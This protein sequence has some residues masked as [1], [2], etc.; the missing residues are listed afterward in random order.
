[1]AR[2]VEGDADRVLVEHESHGV[3]RLD[4]LHPQR[5]GAEV[6]HVRAEAARHTHVV[7]PVTVT[8]TDETVEDVVVRVQADVRRE[9]DLTRL[10][11]N[12]DVVAVVPARIAP[13]DRGE[14]VGHLVERVLVDP[15]AAR[16]LL[17]SE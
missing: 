2:H 14:R 12:A 4:D 11:G 6:L 5:S 16:Q 17:Y 8:Q 10:I 13:G 1:M 15:Q 7:L 9:R 3:Q